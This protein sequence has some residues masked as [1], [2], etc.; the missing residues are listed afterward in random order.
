MLANIKSNKSKVI[1]IVKSVYKLSCENKKRY[2]LQHV[3]T[4]KSA[5]LRK[6][7]SKYTETKLFNSEN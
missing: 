2:V 4:L 3:E 7:Y 1:K 5:F 6:C